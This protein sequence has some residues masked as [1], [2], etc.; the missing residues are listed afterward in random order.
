M[1]RF[2]RARTALVPARQHHVAAAGWWQ[3]HRASKIAGHSGLEM[4]GEYTFVTPERQ[5]ELTRRIQEKLFEASERREITSVSPTPDAPPSPE[6]VTS[7]PRSR[8][9]SSNRK[10]SGRRSSP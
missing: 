7:M 10:P 1:L 9:T 6:A 8:L 2:P 5:N 3:R 4:T